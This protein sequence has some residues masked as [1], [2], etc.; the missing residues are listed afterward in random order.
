MPSPTDNQVPWDRLSLESVERDPLDPLPS[1]RGPRSGLKILLQQ[2]LSRIEATSATLPN[3][4]LARSNLPTTTWLEKQDPTRPQIHAWIGTLLLLLRSCVIFLL[5][6][7]VQS[8]YL[9]SRAE[10]HPARKNP[11][12]YL[13]GLRGVAA[14]SVFFFHF[15]N[16]VYDQIMYAYG[17]PATEKYGE[18]NSL[19]Q[20]PFIKLLYSGPSAVSI[21]FIVSGFALSIK[22]IRQMHSH[23]DAG[24]LATLNSAAF[25]RPI[26]LFLPCF[27]STFVVFLA[28]RLDLFEATRFIAENSEI[29][30]GR[31]KLHTSLKEGF[32]FQFWDWYYQAAGMVRP[33]YWGTDDFQGFYS[34]YDTHLWTVPIEFRA[35]LALFLSHIALARF[36]TAVRIPA[37]FILCI[38]AVANDRWEMLLFWGGMIL[39][40][41]NEGTASLSKPAALL[42]KAWYAFYLANLICGLYLASYP[43]LGG[44]ATP[45]YVYLTTLVP[46]TYKQTRRFWQGIGGFQIVMSV[47]CIPALAR[48]FASGIPRYLGQISFALYL[49]HALVNHTVGYWMLYWMYELTNG[50]GTPFAKSIGFTVALVVDTCAVI[51]AADIFWRLG[52]KPSIAFAKWIETK[53]LR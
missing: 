13:D 27:I 25:R 47:S 41:L 12:G 4:R 48:F 5:P 35:S 50:W 6:T 53:C 38:V 17:G 16:N 7:F 2:F 15:T 24:L 29:L 23:D 42:N 1:A 52:D 9:P 49:M 36:K 14:L 34:E 31:S 32:T 40:E 46:S 28:T 10:Q 8:R 3:W 39:A 26:R 43:D 18:N 20:L 21:F 19:L 11:T 51:W 30:T 44:D 37:V 22:P 33:F 45:G